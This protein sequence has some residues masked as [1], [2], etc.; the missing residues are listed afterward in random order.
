MNWQIKTQALESDGPKFK[1]QLCHWWAGRAW[2][3]HLRHLVP[4]DKM[5]LKLLGL[6]W[7]LNKIMY[8]KH[9]A[10]VYYTMSV[11]QI[12][13]FI[14]RYYSST[15]LCW[16]GA[17]LGSRIW[18]LTSSKAYTSETEWQRAARGHAMCQDLSATHSRTFIEHLLY[19]MY[20]PKYCRWSNEQKRQTW[21]L[22]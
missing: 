21:L 1:S 14:N 9:L 6:F 4:M 11:K 8:L 13:V 19:A 12:I 10:F 5:D 18:S 7:E 17:E 3:T 22:S 15:N 16:H 20:F 2:R